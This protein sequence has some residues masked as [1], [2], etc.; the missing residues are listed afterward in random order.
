MSITFGKTWSEFTRRIYINTAIDKVY[1]AWGVQG[2][3]EKWFLKKAQFFNQNGE[4]R[5]AGEYA[6]QNDSYSWQWHAWPEMDQEGKL[7]NVIQ[8]KLISFDFGEAGKVSV[9]FEKISPKRTQMI[10]TQYDI[11]DDEE[12]KKNYFYG[13]SLG[14]S[15]WM[16]NLKAFLEHGITLDDRDIIKEGSERLQMVNQ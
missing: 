4:P 6:Q 11:P 1:N 16:T 7:T 9:E 15:F 2:E 12:S 5:K 10:L 13:C 8:N 14:W 3:M